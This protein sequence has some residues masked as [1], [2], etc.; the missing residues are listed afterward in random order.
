MR[1]RHTLAVVK[2]VEQHRA[3]LNAALDEIG[4]GWDNWPGVSLDPRLS[5]EDRLSALIVLL[6]TKE[7]EAPRGPLVAQFDPHDDTL[8]WLGRHRE[9]WAGLARARHPWTASTATLAVELVLARMGSGAAFD[10]RP[11]ALALAGADQVC[12]SGQADAALLDALTTLADRLDAEAF[13]YS[14]VKDLNHRTR[15]II[16]SAAPP[17]LLD[18][19]LLVDGDGWVE[20]ARTAARAGPADDVAALVRTLGQL[21]PREPPKIWWRALDAAL[22]PAPARHLLRQWLE[23]AAAAPAVPEWQGSRIGDC[24][25]TLFVGTNTDVIRASALA[26][27]RLRDDRWPAAVLG[28]LARR[29]ADHNGMAGMP[30]ALS[31]K[32]ASAAVEALINRGGNADRHVMRELLDQVQRRDLIKRLT[33][34]LDA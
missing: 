22:V 11:V 30:E 28:T 33:T 15:R 21:G 19:S 31:L 32:V 6:A 1:C 13:E 7:A 17:G 20:P 16:A 9:P 27:T 8:D 34:A 10:D 18:L 24:R 4:L 23:L 2:R 5:S 3:A 29:G 25:G 14:H 12:E 26:T